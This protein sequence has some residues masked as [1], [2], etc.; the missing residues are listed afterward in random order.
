MVAT[1]CNRKS[2]GFRLDHKHKQDDGSHYNEMAGGA[3]ACPNSPVVFVVKFYCSNDDIE[4]GFNLKL[5]RDEIINV[6][7][8]L[9]CHLELH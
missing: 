5:S 9:E 8:L 4:Y 6:T 7:T 1:I 2:I 3:E